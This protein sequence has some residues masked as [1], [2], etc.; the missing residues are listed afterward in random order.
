MTSVDRRLAAI[1]VAD[2]AG[3]SRMMAEDEDGTLAALRAHRTAI[4]PVILNHGGRIV[5]GTGDG[6]IVEFPS[7]TAAL[8]AAVAVQALMNG[9]NQEIPESRRMSFRIGVNLGDVVEGS[10]RRSGGRSRLRAAGRR[11]DRPPC[12]GR[13]LRPRPG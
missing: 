11:R 7:A 13:A 12:V 3:Y 8:E 1:V 4:D 5:K 9:R 2:V 10:V 6:L